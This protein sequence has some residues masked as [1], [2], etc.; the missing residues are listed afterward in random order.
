MKG[1]E[2][3]NVEFYVEFSKKRTFKMKKVSLHS[4]AFAMTHENN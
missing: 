1:T 2:N 3:I 4:N